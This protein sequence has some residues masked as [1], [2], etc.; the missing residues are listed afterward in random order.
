[1][2]FIW[3]DDSKGCGLP[4]KNCN[5]TEGR[6]IVLVDMTQNSMPRHYALA[7]DADCPSVCCVPETMEEAISCCNIGEVCAPLCPD[8]TETKGCS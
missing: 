2:L 4:N 5:G 6:E 7:G 3:W 8:N 1:V